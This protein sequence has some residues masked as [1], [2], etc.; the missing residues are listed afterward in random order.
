MANKPQATLVFAGDADKL[1]KAAKVAEEANKGVQDSV[2]K[3]KDGMQE[4]NQ[5]AKSFGDRLGG[6]G[7]TVTGVSTAFDD[8]AGSVQALAEF[9]DRGRQRAMAHARA[10]A[11]V[12]QATLDA[13]QAAGDLQQANED[14]SQSF[15]DAKQG[16][17][18]ASRAQTDIKRANLEVKEAQIALNEAIKEHGKNSLEAQAAALDLEDAQHDVADANIQA[19][20]AQRDISQA[21]IDGGQAQRDAAQA[22]RDGKDAILDLAEAQREANPPDAQRWASE[23]GS[24]GAAIQGVIGTVSLLALAH[25]ALNVS[26][27]KSTAALVG[28]KIATVA[29]AIASGIATAAQWL[30]N[31]AVAAFPVFL[32]ITAVAA[33][34]AGIVWLATQTTF[35]QDLWKAVWT[36]VKDAAVAA[37]NWIKDAA[38]S[39]AG[40]LTSIPGRI[41]SAFSAITNFIFA[42]FRNAFNLVS[43]A[44]NRTIGSLRWSVP[45][46]VPEIGG[47]SISAPRLPH[48]H[49]GGTVPGLPGEEMLAVLQA[50]ETV[51][52]NGR[53]QGPLI[54]EIKGDGSRA[55]ELLVMLLRDAMEIRSGSVQGAVGSAAL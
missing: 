14:L 45:S 39:T 7:A 25:E 12:E 31:I 38:S 46:W 37:W 24:Y 55:G 53:G 40:F 44:W 36:A 4:G 42:P 27:L 6:L 22:V 34:V 1:R 43:D 52:Q 13:S 11:D 47:N 15:V 35:F 10:L 54:V 21:Q 5:Q 19:E 50:G 23:I 3:V 17:A 26:A 32:I 16:A 49:T 51:S 9:Q 8:A 2:D 20:Q 28:Q 30:W 48:F 33:I 29:S 41:G 18:D